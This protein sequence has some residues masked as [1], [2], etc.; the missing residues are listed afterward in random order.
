MNE[1]AAKAAGI[2]Y[3]VWSEEFAANDRSLAEGERVG[4]IKMILDEKKSPSVC[5]SADRRPASLSASGW[6]F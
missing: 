4:K 6:R 1:K 2:E 3:Q 5:R